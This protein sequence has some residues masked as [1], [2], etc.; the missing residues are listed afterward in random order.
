MITIL[1][2]KS[3]RYNEEKRKKIRNIHQDTKIYPGGCRDPCMVLDSSDYFFY[4]C[5]FSISHPLSPS[6]SM[7]RAA[8]MYQTTSAKSYQV[9]SRISL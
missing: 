7:S 5:Y 4:I 3:K 2:I 8:D 9:N 1:T 6:L